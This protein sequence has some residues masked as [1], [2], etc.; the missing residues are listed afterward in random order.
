ML[1]DSVIQTFK[2]LTV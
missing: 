2:V 1:S